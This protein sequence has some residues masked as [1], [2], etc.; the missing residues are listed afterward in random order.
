MT[1]LLPSPP[2]EWLDNGP[3]RYAKPGHP[4]GLT[5]PIRKNGTGERA[6]DMG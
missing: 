5:M 1:K 6:S 4:R 2:V 3:V